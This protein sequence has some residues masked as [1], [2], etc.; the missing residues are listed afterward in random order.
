MEAKYGAI[1]NSDDH[2]EADW[3]ED[4]AYDDDAES[5]VDTEKEDSTE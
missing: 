5:Y 2:D 1:H 4:G 3:E